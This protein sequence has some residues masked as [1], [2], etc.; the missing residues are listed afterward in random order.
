MPEH[1]ASIQPATRTYRVYFH[2]A[3]VLETDAV[4][5][6]QEHFGDTTMPVVPYFDP[7]VAESLALRPTETSSQCP[8]KG[9]ARYFAFDGVADAIWSY[10][11]PKPA[12]SAIAGHL[13]FDTTKGFRVEAG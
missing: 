6:L 2:D 7:S 12:V 13:G 10:P 4:L 5:E 8:L 1:T 11:N 3:L 9:D